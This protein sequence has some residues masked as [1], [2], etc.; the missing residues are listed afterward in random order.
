MHSFYKLGIADLL[1]DHVSVA[2][3]IQYP[4]CCMNISGRNLFSDVVQ[5]I[6]RYFSSPVPLLGCWVI[7][8]LKSG[9]DF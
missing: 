4:W 9:F 1:L 2:N 5:L 8:I 7:C 6:E 3:A